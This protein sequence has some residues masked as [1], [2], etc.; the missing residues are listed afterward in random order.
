MLP[1]QPQTNYQAAPLQPQG[2]YY[3]YIGM[4]PQA[5]YPTSLRLGGP[6]CHTMAADVQLV[7]T[8]E[9]EATVT[10]TKMSTLVPKA[11]AVV[12]NTVSYPVTTTV[13]DVRTK[14]ELLRMPQL[15]LPHPEPPQQAPQV[16][17][18]A[19]PQAASPPPSPN[20]D[21]WFE[22]LKMLLLG[23]ERPC[24]SRVAASEAVPRAPMPQPQVAVPQVPQQVLYV[25][26]VSHVPCKAQASVH[27][28]VRPRVSDTLTLTESF[29]S[30]LTTTASSDGNQELMTLSITQTS[31]S[32]TLNG[33][34]QPTPG[35][36]QPMFAFKL[37]SNAVEPPLEVSNDLL[38]N[39]FH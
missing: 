20:E 6:V 15:V 5:M 35:P 16:C 22:L 24:E 11:Q 33:M 34:M 29:R 3:N 2:L 17:P 12:T 9:Y 27:L 25:T 1:Q 31:T 23:K 28:G 21:R 10:S 38:Y 19:A 18:M 4:Q 37:G 8:L 32:T 26:L 13:N 30:T 36:N 7:E 39:F 14:V